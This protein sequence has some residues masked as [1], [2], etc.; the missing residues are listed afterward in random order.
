MKK[1]IL[2]LLLF[3]SLLFLGQTPNPTIDTEIWPNVEYTISVSGLPGK[4]AGTITTMRGVSITQ[5]P[6]SSGT[7]IS[8]KAI[9]I[10]VNATQ[11]FK[12]SYEG[13]SQPYELNIQKNLNHSS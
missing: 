1:L 7:S 11:S 6:S 2:S 13:S 12:I 8:F 4:Y 5:Y 10:D 3:Y 9:F